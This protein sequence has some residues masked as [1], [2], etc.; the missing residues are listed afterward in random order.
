[1]ILKNRGIIPNSI[2]TVLVVIICLIGLGFFFM[3][4]LSTISRSD[5]NYQ[6]FDWGFDPSKLPGPNGKTDN[7]WSLSSL[8]ADFGTC[9]GS[10]C[11]S[12]GQTYDSSLNECIGDSTVSGF[13][14]MTETMVNNVL[15]KNSGKH[16]SDYT[17]NG[18]QSIKPRPS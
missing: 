6:E 18:D 1:M 5:M 4:W 3:R 17:M 13:S 12:T 2:Y 8:E 11:C 14:T 9:I 15:I 10:D 16:K 7:P